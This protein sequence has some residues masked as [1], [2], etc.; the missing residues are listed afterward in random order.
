MKPLLELLEDSEKLYARYFELT[1]QG[2]ARELARAALPVAARAEGRGAG[3]DGAQAAGEVGFAV[4][5][6]Q[7]VVLACS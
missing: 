7:A 2:V 4:T 5:I 1:E 3:G 6:M